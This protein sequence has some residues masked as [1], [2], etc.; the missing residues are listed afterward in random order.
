MHNENRIYIF[1]ER[2]PTTYYNNIGK[3]MKET[4]MPEST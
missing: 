3:L 1:K 4:N 2:V